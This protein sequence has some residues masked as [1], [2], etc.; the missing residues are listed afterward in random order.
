M[1]MLLFL[2]SDNIM[3]NPEAYF[4]CL[5]LCTRLQSRLDEPPSELEI[6]LFSYLSCLLWLYKGKPVATWGYTFAVTQ[7]AFPFSPEIHENI[8]ILAYQGMLLGKEHF[9]FQTTEHGNKE[10]EV[11]RSLSTMSEREP[12]L[13]GACSCL[14]A[15]PINQLRDAILQE[16]SIKP[17]MELMQ[18]RNLLTEGDIDR[19]YEQ[20]KAL[21][22]AV[23]VQVDDLMIP[24]IVWIK[25]LSEVN[26]PHV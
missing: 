22:Y 20:F 26:K 17:A 18:S 21:S 4:D 3:V 2:E 1:R 7:Q 23:G 24:A 8:G 9:Y 14:L 13:D 10:Y 25:Y 15:L 6:H 5:A 19:L 16:P 11:L 12:Y